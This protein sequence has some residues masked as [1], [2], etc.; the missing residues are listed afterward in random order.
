MKRFV[1]CLASRLL[2]AGLLAFWLSACENGGAQGTTSIVP[3]HA[4]RPT[5]VS[6]LLGPQPCPG[7]TSAPAYWAPFVHP[8][9]A[10]YIE[11]VSCGYLIGQPLLQAVV[12]LR[13]NSP[14][15]QLT[16]SVFT[17]LAG[18]APVSIFRLTDLPAGEVQISAYNTLLISQQEWQPFQNERILH[19]LTREFTWSDRSRTLV[20]AGFVGLYPDA[21]RYQAEAAQQQV[22]ASQGG[23]GWQLDALSTAQFFAEFLLQWPSASPATVTS[24]GGTHDARAV[25]LVTNPTLAHTAIQVSLSRLELNTNGGIWE[26]TD[27][28]TAGMALT[29][30]YTL[31]QVTSPVPVTGSVLRVPGEYPVLAVLNDEHTIIGQKTLERSGGGSTFSTSVPYTSP[32]FSGE[33]QEGAIALYMLTADQHIA[34]CVMMKVLVQD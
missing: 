34:G 8:A 22:N 25:V 4:A 16:L 24:G 20:Q 10:Q 11:G 5:A 18:P 28:T 29:A 9:T 13:S 1:L 17:G 3:E 6:I 21:T 26:V 12:A 2:L 32:L 14:Q 31:Q 7:Q 27:V 30:P 23:R 19:T 15:R 33:I